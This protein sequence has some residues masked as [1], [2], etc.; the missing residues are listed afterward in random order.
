MPQGF[1]LADKG[2]AYASK[3][4]WDPVKKRRISWAWAKV[5]PGSAQTLPR[6][7][8]YHP[9]L[10]QIVWSP[11]EEQADLRGSVL[12]RLREVDLAEGQ[13]QLIGASAQAEV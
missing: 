8:T 1:Q 13:F 11:A 4:F 12:A 10:K 6:V 9:L 2:D 5:P 7:M 3:D